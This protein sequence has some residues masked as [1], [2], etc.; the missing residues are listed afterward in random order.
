MRFSNPISTSRPGT[1]NTGRPAA[2]SSAAD[3]ARQVVNPPN[4]THHAAAMQTHPSVRRRPWQRAEYM[5]T[6]SMG[7]GSMGAGSMGTGSM[8]MG[9]MGMGPES[10]DHVWPRGGSNNR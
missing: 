9:N 5:G 1:V 3:W 2:K 10:N 8:G 4:P 6:G 7:T